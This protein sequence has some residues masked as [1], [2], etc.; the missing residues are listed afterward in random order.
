MSDVPSISG[1]E[2]IDAFRKHGFEVV[3]TTGSHH[4]MKKDGHPSTLSVPVHGH[5]SLKCGGLI[6][7]SGLSIAE[8]IELL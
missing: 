4:I 7:L 6:R 8:F 3:R 2:A 5:Q 1:S